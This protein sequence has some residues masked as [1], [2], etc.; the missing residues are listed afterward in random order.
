MSR[1]TEALDQAQFGR[2]LHERPEDKTNITEEL[3]KLIDATSLLDVVIGLELVCSEKAEHIRVNWQDKQSANVWDK[4][5]TMLR[6]LARS[7]T[8][9]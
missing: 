6:K 8:N 1:N 2:Q 9:L 7:V 5:S 4:A 3:K